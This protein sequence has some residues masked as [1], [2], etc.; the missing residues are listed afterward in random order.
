MKPDK[1]TAELMRRNKQVADFVASGDWQYVKK[2][3]TD[4]I[5]DLQSIKNL[6]NSDP[7]EL[8][9]EIKARNTAVDIL[10][11]TLR[12]VEADAHQIEKLSIP[13]VDGEFIISFES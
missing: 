12:E 9:M 10:V 13:E 4:K 7:A 5:M 6:E 8:V 11:E 1:E 3:I 2:K